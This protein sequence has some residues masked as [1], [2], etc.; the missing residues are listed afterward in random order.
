MTTCAKPSLLLLGSFAIGFNTAHA[1][2]ELGHALAVW[3]GGG[4]VTSLSLHPFSWSKIGYSVPLT[5]PIAWAGAFFASLV[6]LL[7]LA[8]VWRRYGA[9]TMPIVV[10]ALC[11]FIVN[12]VYL[13][14]DGMLLAGGDATDLVGLGVSR[15]VVVGAGILLLVIGA[16]IAMLLPPRLGLGQQSGLGA[17]LLVLWTGIGSYLIA[18]F[19]YHLLFNAKEV[20]VWGL[21]A[22]LG[23]LLISVLAVAFPLLENRYTWICRQQAGDPGWKW[24]VATV[25]AGAAAVIAE[26]MLLKSD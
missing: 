4:S 10:T 7:L 2:H 18:M 26:L 22:G 12:A 23:L 19:S 24:P 15:P 5:V 11:T 17:R 1:L 16:V 14:V 6:G 13:G 21:F 20:L 3:F 25:A 9:W 8:L